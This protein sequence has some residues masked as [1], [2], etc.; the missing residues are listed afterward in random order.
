MG[1]PVC[2]HL[3]ICGAW[4]KLWQWSDAEFLQS[5]D[6]ALLLMK[7]NVTWQRLPEGSRMSL[8]PACS[9][10]QSHQGWRKGMEKGLHLP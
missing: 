10:E 9:R 7:G 3:V 8:S 5:Q 1:L 2:A 6:A 4:V